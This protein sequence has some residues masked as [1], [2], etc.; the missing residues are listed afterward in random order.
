MLSWPRDRKIGHVPSLPPPQAAG[1]VFID[2]W[3]SSEEA[4]F[5]PFFLLLPWLTDHGTQSLSSCVIPGTSNFYLCPFCFFLHKTS[6]LTLIWNVS[7]YHGTDLRP[8][9]WLWGRARERRKSKDLS[10]GGSSI[11]II[12]GRH[13]R[14]TA[15]CLPSACNYH[16]PPARHQPENYQVAEST[17]NHLWLTYT[18]R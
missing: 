2:G 13:V 16:R 5:S 1:K 15:A 14:D 4:F 7:A 8:Q 3:N 17:I 10:D 12:R 9:S 6:G 18:T 11:R